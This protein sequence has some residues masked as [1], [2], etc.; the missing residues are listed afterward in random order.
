ME[1]D[2]GLAWMVSRY[3]GSPV[4]IDYRRLSYATFERRPA[5]KKKMKENLIWTRIF[6]LINQT[7]KTKIK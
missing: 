6:F 3:L 1:K 7:P 5:K 4:K 2:E